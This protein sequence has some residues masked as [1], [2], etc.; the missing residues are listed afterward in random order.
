MEDVYPSS[1][2][3]MEKFYNI[4]ENMEDLINDKNLLV[5]GPP[6]GLNPKNPPCTETEKTEPAPPG[7]IY[8]HGIRVE[9]SDHR[10]RSYINKG[11][12]IHQHGSTP[13]C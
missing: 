12:L 11:E 2:E 5:T 7:P 9:L 4:T 8:V 3:N 13:Q 10:L 6:Q 1:N